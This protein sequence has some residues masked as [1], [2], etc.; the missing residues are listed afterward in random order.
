MIVKVNDQCFDSRDTP[1]MVVLS[2]GEKQH[3]AE[4]HPECV[5]YASVPDGAFASDD[6]MRAWMIQHPQW[7]PP[8]RPVSE[9]P[10]F[11]GLGWSDTVWAW[12]DDVQ[13]WTASRYDGDSGMWYS[14]GDE[15][16]RVTWWLPLSVWPG[17]FQPVA[18]NEAGE[19]IGWRNRSD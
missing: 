6:E 14:D 13:D 15:L 3:I 4:M 1:V 5:R 11:Q 9:P 12:D 10:P 7:P 18:E 17:I 2:P 8:P 19:V 16:D